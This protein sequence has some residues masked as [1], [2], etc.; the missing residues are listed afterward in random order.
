[1]VRMRAAIIDGVSIAD[2]CRSHCP[3]QHENNFGLG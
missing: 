3:H 1:V 2:G